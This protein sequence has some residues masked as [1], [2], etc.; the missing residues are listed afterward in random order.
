MA[1]RHGMLNDAVPGVRLG[2]GGYC[3]NQKNVHV[4]WSWYMQVADGANR[5][6]NKT[7]LK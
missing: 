7:V 5:K 4:L 3:L 1:P 2:M 6:C